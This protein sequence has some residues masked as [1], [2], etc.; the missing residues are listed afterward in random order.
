MRGRRKW[1]CTT[2]SNASSV[3]AWP[4]VD[5]DLMAVSGLFA[6][7]MPAGFYYKTFMWP[8]RFWM[9]YEHFIRKASGLG[10]APDDPDP[11][12]YDKTNAHCDVLVAGGGPAGLAAAWAAGRAGARVILADEQQRIRRQPARVRAG[13][14]PA[15]GGSID[16]AAPAAW[17]ARSS[18][19]CRRCPTC[20]CFRAAPCSVTTT[21]TS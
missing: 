21:T 1:R 18:P 2:G 5:L 9:R 4:S 12:V 19:S 15:H 20:D 17:V 7:L 6:R 8:K 3:N 10:V 16:G 14:L 13:K 11:D